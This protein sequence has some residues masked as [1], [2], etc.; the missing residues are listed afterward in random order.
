[1]RPITYATGPATIR[2][3]CMR[4]LCQYEI[5]PERHPHRGISR[6]L[7]G[8]SLDAHGDRMAVYVTGVLQKEEGH[9]L[10]VALFALPRGKNMRPISAMRT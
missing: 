6:H 1:M 9:I 7:G 2:D 4:V 3:R 8:Y 10:L 5:L